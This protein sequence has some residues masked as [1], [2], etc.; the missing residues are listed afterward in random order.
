MPLAEVLSEDVEVATAVD[1]GTTEVV[2][3]VLAEIEGTGEIVEGTVVGGAI[4][5]VGETVVVEETVVVVVEVA[6][7]GAAVAPALGWFARSF[8]ARCCLRSSF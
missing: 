2:G 7:V 6:A 1:G 3:A 4:A 8:F 5:G